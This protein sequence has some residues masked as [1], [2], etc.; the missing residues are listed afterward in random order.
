MPTADTFVTLADSMS[1]AIV[2]EDMTTVAG[3]YAADAA[4]LPPGGLI[5]TGIDSVQAFWQ[6]I[7]DRGTDFTHH[8]VTAERIVVQPEVVYEYG[9]YTVRTRKAD[10]TESDTR[11]GK[12]TIVW[13]KQPAG[14]WKIAVDAWS[15]TD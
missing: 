9:Y 8:K 6:A 13:H 14:D 1:A 15:G 11:K 5:K 12:Y 2:H 4:L 7:A 3:F 10:G